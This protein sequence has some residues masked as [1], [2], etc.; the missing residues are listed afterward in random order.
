MN[1]AIQNLSRNRDLRNALNKNA[2]C[3][4]LFRQNIQKE[5]DWAKLV[6]KL[7]TKR[8]K[9]FALNPA[10]GKGVQEGV[11]QGVNK[12]VDWSAPVGLGA[13]AALYDQT[14]GE[15]PV[16]SIAGAI[17]LP[18]LAT[19][20]RARYRDAI[21][22]G[23]KGMGVLTDMM[24]KS[25]PEL[26]AKTGVAGGALTAD[27]LM[28]KGSELANKLE[29]G[30][31]SFQ[32][33]GK[34]AEAISSQ[35]KGTKDQ[36][37][38]VDNVNRLLG[39]AVTA[40]KHIGTKFGGNDPEL[41]FVG[42][43]E[44]AQRLTN[45]SAKAQ[46]IAAQIK[47]LPAGSAELPALQSQYTEQ[48]G[49]ANNAAGELNKAFEH[50]AKSSAEGISSGVDKTLATKGVLDPEIQASLQKSLAKH[51]G[52][53][54]DGAKKV[55]AGLQSLKE[56]IN[57]TAKGTSDAASI[58]THFKDNW[59]KYAI[60]GGVL[61][62]VVGYAMYRKRQEAEE[63]EKRRAADI[64]RQKEREIKALNRMARATEA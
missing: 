28:G 42:Q 52:T 30:V 62:A 13:G 10:G 5:A 9:D 26:A 8:L 17:M 32:Q 1:K 39:G 54:G 7:P 55:K 24:A 47:A 44:M 34:N 53:G 61:S 20:G 23:K 21:A 58:V 38:P 15:A 35:V 41:S 57:R 49:I 45:S 64:E 51:R 37:G 12:A 50:K 3:D 11:A 56:N 19:R 36:P 46:S 25:T 63:E 18:W 31:D 33:V 29:S 4:D 43:E 48:Q 40:G 16:S 60:G 2:T 6:S 14:D 59:G 22:G 27:Y